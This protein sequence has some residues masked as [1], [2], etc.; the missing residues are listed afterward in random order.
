MV[1]GGLWHGANWTFVVWGAIHGAGLAV[2][3]FFTGKTG[4]SESR[5]LAGVWLRRIVTFHIVCLTWIFFRA[6]SVTEAITLLR[7]L[8][9]FQW[10]PVFIE[11]ILFLGVLALIQLTIDLRLETADEEYIFERRPQLSRFAAAVAAC[12]LVFLFAAGES[13]AFIYFQF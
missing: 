9:N 12:V 13:N 8:G 7:G 3:R 4:Q 2:E 11:A 1:L 6:A 5:H 10:S